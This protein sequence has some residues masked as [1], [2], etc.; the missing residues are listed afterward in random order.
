MQFTDDYSD[1]PP[2]MLKDMFKINLFKTIHRRKVSLS[3]LQGKVVVLEFS[4]I[5]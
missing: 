5:T 2:F 4:A 3:G 1:N